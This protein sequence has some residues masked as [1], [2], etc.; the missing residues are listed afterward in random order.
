MASS[1]IASLLLEN[2]RTSHFKLKIPLKCTKYTTCDI[3]PNTQLGKLIQN[4]K[5]FIWDEAPML[6]KYCFET[7]DRTFRDLMKNKEPKLAEIPFG[8]KVMVFGGDFRQTLPVVRHGNRSAV[9]SSC[10]NRSYLWK[11]MRIYNFTI[12]KRI[13]LSSE[14]NKKDQYA[15]SKYLIDVGEG[16]EKT[17]R[18]LDGDDNLIKLP[19]EICMDL[20]NPLELIH[21]VYEDIETKYSD[22]NYIIDRAILATTNKVCDILNAQVLNLIPTEDK[23]Y[24]S[25]DS[26]IGENDASL[27]PTEYLNTLTFTGLPPHKLHLKK[28]AVV[29]CLRNLNTSK[30]L[31]NGT[32][33]VIRQFK[34]HVI[35]CEII[36]GTHKGE[37]IFLPRISLMPNEEDFPFEFKRRQFPIKLAFSMTVK[38]SQGQTI[39]KVGFYVDAP[40]FNHGQLYTVMSRVTEKSALKIMLQKKEIEGQYGF[41]INNIV[42]K[43]VFHNLTTST[44]FI[45][46]IKRKYIKC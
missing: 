34:E 13:E 10:L 44:K 4:A 42:Y 7:V 37:R 14:T 17:Y 15:F 1:G 31:C 23:T 25:A 32:R 3:K 12:N 30:G 8:G 24:N 40:L 43:E 29:I 46:K 21:Q 6:D 2:G 22:I 36:T 19:D 33:L 38:K 35:D 11:H 26:T 27:Y 28:N 5:I 41:F 20:T 39:K 18:T 16:T 9:V 45:D